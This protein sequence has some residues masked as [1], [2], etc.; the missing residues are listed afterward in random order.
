MSD[1]P[2]TDKTPP[3]EG[4]LPSD[5]VL[6]AVVE[7]WV[8]GRS[9]HRVTATGTS[10]L[11]LIREGDALA[12]AHGVHQ[13]RCGDVVLFRR[14]D[15]LVAHRVLRVR[16]SSDGVTLLTKGDNAPNV[17]PPVSMDQVIGRITHIHKSDG[18]TICITGRRWQIAGWILARLSWCAAV[19]YGWGRSFRMRLG[20]STDAGGSRTGERFRSAVRWMRGKFLRWVSR[21]EL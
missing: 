21:G 13:W 17:D 1:D 18:R 11:P 9:E 15:G 20:R 12:V 4:P 6:D 2:L 10:M 14:P 19:V 3:R 5:A 7:L 16:R 8:Q